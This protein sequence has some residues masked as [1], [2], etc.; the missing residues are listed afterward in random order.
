ML[1]LLLDTSVA[2]PLRD[3][4]RATLAR[5]GGTRDRL[6]ISIISR[7]ALE[8]GVRSAEADAVQRMAA[9]DDMLATLRVIPF[10]GAAADAYRATVAATGFSRRRTLDR[11]I[12]VTAIAN[13]L[14]LATAN[15]PDFADIGGLAVETWP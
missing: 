4:D 2:I 1:D 7:I 6:A 13:G 9:L 15:A 11:M 14:R 10:D 8:N 5:L 3:G 12:A